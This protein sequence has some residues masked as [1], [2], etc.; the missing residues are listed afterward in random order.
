MAG[1]T[2][3]E[4]MGGHSAPGVESRLRQIMASRV[5]GLS[6]A[7]VRADGVRWR[8]GLGLADLATRASATSDTVY[9]WFSMTKI[10][11][12]TAVVQ[13]ADR[14][15]LA[16]D[17]PVA[18]HYPR[19]ASLRPVDRAARVTTRHLLSHRG[20]LANPIP[21]R[22]VHPADQPA[23]DPTA[24]VDGLLTRHPKFSF[25]P[26]AKAKYSNLGFLV[27]GQVIEATTGRRFQDHVRE[28][29]LEPLGMRRTGF[30][31]PADTAAVAT[32]YQRRRSLMTPLL[33]RL[34]P[35]G[36]IGPNQDG[37]LSFRRFYVDG[38][39]YGGLVGP[40]EDAARFLQLHLRDGELDGTRILAAQS[41]L[42]MRQIHTQG[43]RFDLGLGWFRP[44][45]RR[46]TTPAFVQHRGDGG[47]F[48]TDMR[49]YPEAALGI[50]MM[51]NATS[52]DRDQIASLLAERWWHER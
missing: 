5:P 41:A 17:D 29:I 47:A 26:G 37:Y 22:W 40:V 16:L 49:I 38:P 18:H 32:G 20:G 39:A 1:L 34:L 51:G 25:E 36:I 9:L 33:R 50:V 30:T 27:L 11:T 15:R 48:A 3:P 14:G 31:Y 52:Y 13:L 42:S 7:V 4:T 45:K 43:R 46:A 8:C 35:A 2:K 28:A 6:V 23:P 10:V 19:F 21:V 44:A 24:L 12:A